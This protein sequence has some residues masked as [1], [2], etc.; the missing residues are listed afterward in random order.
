ENSFAELAELPEQL[1]A[2]RRGPVVLP[3][4]DELFLDLGGELASLVGRKRGHP[5]ARAGLRSGIARGGRF[6]D[7]GGGSAR[8]VAGSV[9]GG[10]RRRRGGRGRFLLGLELRL[11]LLGRD[12][13][14]RRLLADLLLAAVRLPVRIVFELALERVLE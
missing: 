3:R 1:R 11:E 7:R 9:R 10:N 5:S 6:R 12:A 8:D 13:E 4:V 14:L 2:G